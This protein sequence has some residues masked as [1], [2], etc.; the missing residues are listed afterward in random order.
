[1]I[2]AKKAGF[3]PLI[4]VVVLFV[5]NESKA[6]RIT[7]IKWNQFISVCAHPEGVGF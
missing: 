6:I 5:T 3:L 2:T 7:V 4:F 1:M